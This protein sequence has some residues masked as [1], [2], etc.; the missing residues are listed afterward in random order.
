MSENLKDILSNLNGDTS[1]EKL[2]KYLNNQ[3]SSEEQHEVEK[4]LLDDEFDNDAIDGLQEIQNKQGL[5]LMVDALN[6][7]LRKKL[8]KQKAIREK[9]MLKPQWTVY[10]SIIILLI[11]LALVYFYIRYYAK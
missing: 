2:L 4:N 3:L 10:F 9:R 7:D 5:E 11:I 8:N 1:Q 6:R